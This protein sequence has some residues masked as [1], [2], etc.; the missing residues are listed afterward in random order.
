M[1][2]KDQRARVLCLDGGGIRGLILTRILKSM[3]EIWGTPINHCFDWIA[4]T[5]TGCILALSLTTGKTVAECTNLYFNVRDKVMIGS[6]PYDTKLF[7]DEL[8][9]AFGMTKMY[10]IKHPKVIVTAT[11]ADRSP[12]DLHLFRNYPSPQEIVG[13]SDYPHPELSRPQ[14]LGST[15]S[16][17]E[18][19][20]VW[21]AARASGAAPAVFRPDGCFVDGG[22]LANNPT[23]DVL[24]EIAEY[25]Q[26]LRSVDRVD[27]VV[28]PEVVLSLGTG[29]SPVR[30]T[31]VVDI[32]RPDNAMD[33]AKLF[34]NWDGMGKLMM[35][36]VVD[37]DNRITDRCRA[38][39]SMVGIPYYR[40]NPYMA[41]DIELDEKDN[42]I[43]IDLMWDTMAYVYSRK[44]DVIRL[45]EILLNHA[46]DISL[47]TLAQMAL[48][49]DGH[50]FEAIN[51]KFR[52]LDTDGDGQLTRAEL[53]EHFGDD[54]SD[55]V[56]FTI[57][58]MDLDNNGVIEFHEFLEM[59]A[60]LDYKKGISVDKIKQF[61]RALDEDGS[62]T[63]SSEEIR[64]FHK[65]M[66]NCTIVNS[67]ISSDE[68]V[69]KLV[70]KLDINGDGKIDCEEFI[71]GYIL[72]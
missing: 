42:K 20:L 21:K 3:E 30:K 44:E 6:K 24:T 1:V 9:K 27:E 18:E 64:K 43:L 54:N 8:Q 38:W 37:T 62:G 53:S 67:P 17:P 56:E 65:V 63:L 57:K 23:L 52:A 59:T 2:K 16:H 36:S 49:L 58:L 66:S 41:T 69:E 25:N 14:S 72:P 61:F 31:A 29:V 12:P 33:T 32:F 46:P 39:C 60:F 19:Q 22:I 15:T 5:S 55:K 10:D 71:L 45:K 26:A 47:V 4:G 13:V 68:E 28:D 34:L 35:N 51:N 11:M 50:E 7:D 48:Q 70:S 40:F